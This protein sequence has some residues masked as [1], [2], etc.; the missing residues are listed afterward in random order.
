MVR[1][2]GG[3]CT[4]YI[5][6][7]FPPFPFGGENIIQAFFIYL[8]TYATRTVPG[9]WDSHTPSYERH[10]LWSGD[11]KPVKN[12]RSYLQPGCPNLDGHIYTQDVPNLDGHI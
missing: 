10:A 5:L 2:R 6:I 9:D 7:K 12:S 11:G 8:F 4:L 1:W 3:K